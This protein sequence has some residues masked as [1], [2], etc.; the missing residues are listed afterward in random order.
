MDGA[1]RLHDSIPAGERS[2]LA[3]ADREL[4][5][6][7]LTGANRLGEARPLIGGVLRDDP[8]NPVRG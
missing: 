2:T 8:G 6:L 4:L 5:I 1:L 7:E 3:L